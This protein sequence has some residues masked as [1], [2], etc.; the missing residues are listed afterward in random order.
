MLEKLEIE[1][2]LRGFS[3]IT[4]NTYMRH[5]RSFLDY[6]KKSD[7]EIGED[8]IKS[9]L[10]YIINDK[11]VKP[12]SSSLTLSALK[13]YYKEILEK[14][15]FRRIKTPKSEKKIPIV[16]TKDEIKR[17]LSVTKNFKHKLILELMYSSGLRVSEVVKMKVNDLDLDEK[18]GKVISGKGRKDRHIILSDVMISSLRNYLENRKDDSEYV[19]PGKKHDHLSI[20]MAQKLIK[21]SAKKAEIKKRVFCHALRSSFATHLL[22]NGTDIRIIQELLGHSNLSTTERY[23]K[24]STEQLKK[25][26]SP[27]DVL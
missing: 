1:L 15:I 3:D 12:A 26:K 4:I 22:E 19:F 13:F 27:L 11:K 23:T 10:A 25:V 7:A 2:K 14:E 24:V 16:L 6:V 20:R 9:Y 21:N 5:N 18:M 8:D 17:L